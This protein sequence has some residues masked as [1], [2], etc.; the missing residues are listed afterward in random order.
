M[1]KEKLSSW[2]KES[3][4]NI[5]EG[6]TLCDIHIDN[7]FDFKFN[8]KS[9]ILS[10][11]IEILLYCVKELNSEKEKLQIEIRIELKSVSNKIQG[12]PKDIITLTNSI[13]GDFVPELLLFPQVNKKDVVVIENYS[14]PLPFELIKEKGDFH[15]IYDEY[16]DMDDFKDE[17]EYTRWLTLKYFT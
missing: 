4:I 15:F 5:Y 9:L 16:R 2:L 17:L 8:K 3:L 14:C 12:V 6:N 11:S 13:N 10:S 1:E 7:F